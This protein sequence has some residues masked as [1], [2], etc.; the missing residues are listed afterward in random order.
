MTADQTGPG[1]AALVQVVDHGDETVVGLGEVVMARFA[2]DEG[3]GCVRGPFERDHAFLVV[4]A[5]IGQGAVDRVGCSQILDD[6]ELGDLG[7][8]IGPFDAV[9]GCRMRRRGA[10][11]RAGS[12]PSASVLRSPVPGNQSG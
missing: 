6:L 1:I 7:G 10:A 3:V 4:H 8:R 12:F 2:V 9:P 5:K 11:T